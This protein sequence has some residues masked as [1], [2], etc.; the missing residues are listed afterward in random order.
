MHISARVRRHGYHL[1]SLASIGMF[2]CLTL[3]IAMLAIAWQLQAGKSAGSD[4]GNTEFKWI[5]AMASIAL[6]GKLWALYRLRIIG[7]L[8]YAG[9]LI[10]P[11]MARAWRW[12][13]NAL[14]AAGV[15]GV[16]TLNPSLDLSA[17]NGGFDV[18]TGIDPSQIY[19]MLLSCLIS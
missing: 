11:A 18:T 3:W 4:P 10:S 9:D 12:L 19:F 14:V 17:R 1:V 8:L 2:V 7:K 16:V 15:L 6:L 5:L 13:G